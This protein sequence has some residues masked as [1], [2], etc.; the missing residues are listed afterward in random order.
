LANA[1]RLS[2][3]FRGPAAET[4]ASLDRDRR[5][6]GVP[7]GGQR[8]GRGSHN[9]RLIPFPSKHSAGWRVPRDR[10]SPAG[11]PPGRW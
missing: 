10:C 9:Q 11:L 3:P 2:L 8:R 1:H 4:N 5:W 7:A 6:I